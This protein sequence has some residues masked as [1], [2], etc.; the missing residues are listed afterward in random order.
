MCVCVGGCGG[1]RSRQ[2]T[3]N[4][5]AVSS[6]CDVFS[7]FIVISLHFPFQLVI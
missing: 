5:I 7:H 1:G 6:L 3:G 4:T 2:L